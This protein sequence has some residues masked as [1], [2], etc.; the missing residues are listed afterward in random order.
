MAGAGGGVDMDN[1]EQRDFWSDDAG[2]IWIDQRETMDTALA[3]VLDA[4]LDWSALKPGER[5]MDIGCGAGTS[6]FETG[7]QVGTDGHVL[8]ADISTSLLAEARRRGAD[9]PNVDFALC[10]A[11]T[12]DFTDQ[13]RD[14]LLS[15]F[16]V[17]FFAN[18]DD[19]FANMSKAL[20]PKGRMVF[21]TWGAIPANPY[22]TLPAAVSKI[23][24]GPRERTD[25]DAPG[26]FALRDIDRVTRILRGA[27]LTDITADAIEMDLTPPGAAEDVAALMCQ[28]GPAQAALSHFEADEAQRREMMA[29]L[30]DALDPYVTP[31]GIRIPALINLFSATRP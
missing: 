12:E 26:P 11:A 28:I 19:A 24:L 22:F 21:A 9:H 30:I 20:K 31:D 1:S 25:P 17:M 6:S 16:G 10:D 13:K 29:F 14:I 23:V 3:P 27:D 7:A 5:A 8:G 4:V 2:Q 15:R 18:S